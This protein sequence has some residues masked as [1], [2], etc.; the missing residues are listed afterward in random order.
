MKK[1]LAKRFKHA[2]PKYRLLAITLD[3]FYHTIFC[4]N[5]DRGAII[6]LRHSVY[7]NMGHDIVTKSHIEYVFQGYSN[8][9]YQNNAQ[10][11]VWI[12]PEDR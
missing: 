4:D 1:E 2:F 9:E 3:G 6:K 8:S 5:G 10:Q 11:I 12:N 7:E